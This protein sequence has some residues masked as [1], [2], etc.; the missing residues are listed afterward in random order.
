[1]NPDLELAL[2][3]ID[4]AAEM[5]L[6][7]FRDRDFRVTI[8]P[9]GSPVT[10]VDQAVERALR[11][12]L[13]ER[14]PEHAVLGEEYG[15]SGDSEW[16]WY[17][18]P[19]D[20][21]SRFVDG[22]PNWMTF[23]ALARG[24]QIALGAVAVP[25]RSERWWASKG[26]GAFHDGDRLAVS[27]T[28]RLE[29]AIV[30]DDWRGTLENGLP[31]R[32]L[33]AV[34]DR[35]RGVRPRNGH[36]FLAVAA[37]LADVALSGGGYAWD[38]AAPKLIVEEAGGRFSDLAGRPRIDSRNAMVTNGR[39]HDEVLAVVAATPARPPRRQPGP[40]PA[41]QLGGPGRWRGPGRPT[42]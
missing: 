4:L 33:T 20:G 14:R 16:C 8:K 9:D 42:D 22:D 1:M 28:P 11:E 18:D 27:A 25:G 21:T 7:R 23:V 29:D 31:G 3:L 17:L 5:A 34:A 24:D 13:T 39:L 6:P 2:E 40:E 32:P 38:Y 41:R 35:A 19:I 12:V 10:D 37:G 30:N 26:E 15:A 36:G